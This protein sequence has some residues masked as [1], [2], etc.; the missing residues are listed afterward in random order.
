VAFNAEKV[1]NVKIKCFI[2]FLK[3]AITEE[4][5]IK[6]MKISNQKTKING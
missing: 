5:K 1:P 4:I 3:H 6:F 2:R